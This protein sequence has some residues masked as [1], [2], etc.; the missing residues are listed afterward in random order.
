MRAIVIAGTHSGVGKTSI[1]VGIMAA[2]T[3]RGLKV[4]PFKVGPD[5]IDP[6]HHQRATGRVS[7]NLDG[8]MLSREFNVANFWRHAA[9]ADIALIEGVMGLFD[10]YHGKSESGSTA[11]VAKWLGAPV[12]LVLDA[13][14]LSRSAAALIQ[15]YKNFDPD[16]NVAGVVF[17]KIAGSAHLDWLRQ[18]VAPCCSVAILGGIPK[19]KE[20]EVPERHLGLLM[21]YEDRLTTRYVEKLADLVEAN[22]NLDE[23]LR[24]AECGLPAAKWIGKGQSGITTPESRAVRFGVARDAAFCFY[25]QDNLDLLQETGAEIVEFSPLRDRRLPGHLDALYL[26]GGYP[27]LYAEQLSENRPLLAE[28][29]AF[30]KKGGIVYGECGGLM[31]LSQGIEDSSGRRFPLCGVFPFWTRMSPQLKLAYAEVEVAPGNA[32]FPA[33]RRIRGHVFHFSELTGPPQVKRTYHVKTFSQSFSEGFQLK[34][35]LASYL[36]LHFGSNPEFARNL[37]RRSYDSNRRLR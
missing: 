1:S 37:V 28:V 15:G 23:I 4:Q 3:R 7:R 6:G 20:V 18:A 32:L 25:Y 36:H 22:L 12:L 21:S 33:G 17:N 26:G 29:R 19:V 34:N 9:D 24:I 11:E 10:G 2:L 27:E 14:A 30:S 13:W 31:Y 5:F 16:L 35:T 8:W